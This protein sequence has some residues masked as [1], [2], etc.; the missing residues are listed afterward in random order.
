[1]SELEET[2]DR[3]R[4]G[5]EPLLEAFGHDITANEVHAL[6]IG[7]SGFLVATTVNPLDSLLSVMLVAYAIGG[8]P[9]FAS[10]PH[11]DD[12]Y[13]HSIGF[14]TIKHEPWFFLVTYIPAYV[15]GMSL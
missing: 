10:L 1:M 3:L 4:E 15:I 11:T 13:E 6:L 14:K 9:A 7:C 5:Q 12:E 2:R 8:R